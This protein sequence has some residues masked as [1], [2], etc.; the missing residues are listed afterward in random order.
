MAIQ[1]RLSGGISNA[2]PNASLGAAMSSVEVTSDILENLFDNI[3]RNEILVGRTEYRLLYITNTS[4]TVTGATV[5]ISTNPS[6]S[7]VSMGLDIAGK[8]DGINTGVAAAIATEITVPTSIKFFGEDEASSDGPYDTVRLPV[9]MLKAGEAVGIWLKRVT[10]PGAQQVVTINIDVVHDAVSLPGEDFDDGAAIGELI[11][12]TTA[13]GVEALIG[14]ARI[15]FSE[16][17][18]NP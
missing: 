18:A 13:A 3:K 16:I 17:A 14:T 6:I 7:I 4:G 1:F 11:Q 8:G 10:E 9:G 15:G 12:I 2:L 5:E